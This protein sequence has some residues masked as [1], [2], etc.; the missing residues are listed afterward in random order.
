MKALPLAVVLVLGLGGCSSTDGGGTGGAGSE[1]GAGGALGT[2][3]SGSTGG[4]GAGSVSGAGGA[5]AGGGTGGAPGGSGC[6]AATVLF[7]EDFEGHAAD[8]FPGAPWGSTVVGGSGSEIGSVV[9][10]AVT[11]AFSG[12]H[13][14]KVVN[15]GSYQTFLSLTG[16]PV[17]PLAAGPLYVRVYLRLSEAMS[18]GHNTY[19]KAGASGA[20]SSEHETRVGVMYE[21]LM[22][23]QPAGD[24]G[25]LSNESY[26]TDQQLG[27]VIEP[28][29][30][31]CIEGAFDPAS[32][33]ISVALGGTDIPDLHVTDWQQD[34][35]GALHFGFEQYAGPGTTL[36]Y[37]DIVVSTAPIGCAE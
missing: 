7:C 3:G 17:F 22:I 21:M 6:D 9:V 16:A 2:G 24:R 4:G 36:W 35:I 23:N 28:E 1:T 34:P 30:W 14:A 10:D 31:T 5:V 19:F 11:P 33:T 29:T 20:S 15:R 25:F 18:G 32:S 12:A 37:D 13:S 8:A 27:A 26:W